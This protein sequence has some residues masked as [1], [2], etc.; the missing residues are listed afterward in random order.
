MDFISSL[1][2]PRR[3]VAA[4]PPRRLPPSPRRSSLRWIGLLF[5]LLLAAANLRL[6]GESLQAPYTYYKDFSYDYISAR[7]VLAGE[8]P[9]ADAQTLTRRHL[10]ESPIDTPDHPSSHTPLSISLVVP[11]AALLSYSKAAIAWCLLEIGM[12]LGGAILFRRLYLGRQGWAAMPGALLTTLLFFAWGPVKDE[13]GNGQWTMLL[14]LLLLAVWLFLRA[15]R[16]RLGGITLGLA[17][18]IKLSGAPILLFLLLR[19]QWRAA[20]TALLTAL[21]GNLLAGLVIGWPPLLNYYLHIGAYVTRYYRMAGH[22][23]SLWTTGWRLFEGSLRHAPFGFSA[24][25]LASLPALA[26]PASIAICLAAA[27]IGLRAAFR[28]KERDEAF[29]LLIYLT[30]LL[31]PV[32]WTYHI[33][34]TILPLGMTFGHLRQRGFPRKATMIAII[35]FTIVSLPFAAILGLQQTFAVADSTV[36]AGLR[37]SFAVGMLSLLPAAGLI[38]LGLLLC[39]LTPP[40]DRHTGK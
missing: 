36:A 21:G 7:A 38:G 24:P 30:L 40:P 18:A 25:A 14:L 29:G 22:N 16:E 2:S 6:I 10:A 17:L 32:S 12:I 5:G 1:F 4:S 31:N 34:L 27:A 15:G 23:Y 9:Y 3:R 35:L 19:R 28:R 11:L 39:R 37:I 26:R 8:D 20:T 33:P 13:L